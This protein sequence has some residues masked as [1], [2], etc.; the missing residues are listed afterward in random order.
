[1]ADLPFDRIILAS[2]NQG[3]IAELRAMVTPLGLDV[4]SA[5]DL[6]LSE[7]TEDQDTFVG[8]ATKKAK[9]ICKAT[10]L[11]TLADDSGLCVDA[12]DGAP[13]VFTARYSRTYERLM[14]DI[15]HIPAEQRHAHFICV[16]AFALPNGALK[17]FEGRAD[18]TIHTSPLGEGGFGYDPVF[19]PAGETRTFAQMTADEK[20]TH[21]HRG[22]A[23]KQFLD[24]LKAL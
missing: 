22:K 23:M 14:N 17:T 7:V 12:L 24:Y 18:G 20:K 4:L 1:M 21:S 8:N 3:K 9:E 5:H 6:D 11:P 13:G 16:L 10:N 2:H 15:A 19:I